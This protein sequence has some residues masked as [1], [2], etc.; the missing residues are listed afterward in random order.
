MKNI[1]FYT[2]TATL[3]THELDAMSNH[4]WRVLPLTSWLTDEYGILIFL[5]AHI[6]LFA[7]LI[8]L[9]AST[10]NS[11]RFRSRIGIS[12]F[13]VVH[14]LLHATFMGNTSY[15]F[16]AVSSNVLIFGGAF[17]GAMHLFAESVDQH[18]TSRGLPKKNQGGNA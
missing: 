2:G 6:P 15:E 5:F 17:L 3:I 1:I 11:I 10:K 12:I 14:G 16:A 8:A 9:I 13:L 4:E 18:K 7:V